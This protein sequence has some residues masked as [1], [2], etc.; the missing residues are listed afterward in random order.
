LPVLIRARKNRVTEAPRDC[1]PADRASGK[2]F[3]GTLGARTIA[4]ARGSTRSLCSRQ[5]RDHASRRHRWM[6]GD[7]GSTEADPESR[8]RSEPPDGS[9][10][11][12]RLR[13]DVRACSPSR[14]IDASLE[15]VVPT[16]F[17][18]V[19]GDGG[20]LLARLVRR[21]VCESRTSGTTYA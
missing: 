9:C 17:G 2:P 6:L 20:R 15:G 1:K 7:S 5:A 18:A 21:L 16:A 12:A 4:A 19:D 13:A 11:L 3:P 8:A 10:A 14:R